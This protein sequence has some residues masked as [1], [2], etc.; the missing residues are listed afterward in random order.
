MSGFLEYII[1]EEMVYPHLKASNWQDALQKGGKLL[2][3]KKIAEQ[4]YVDTMISKVNEMGPYFILAPGI[5]M[6][7]GRPE[8]GVLETGYAVVTLSEPVNFGD[9]DNDPIWL[10]IFMGAKDKK[11]HNQIAIA[12]IADF[13][14]LEDKLTELF[15]CNTKEE[16]LLKMKEMKQYI[17]ENEL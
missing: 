8:E 17:E 14:D 12:Q 15:Q 7:H 4:R 9:E 1:K 16:M 11:T 6:P 5:A 10:L 3:D 2:I 13:C